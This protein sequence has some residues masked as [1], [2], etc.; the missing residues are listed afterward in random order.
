MKNYN[1]KR[2]DLEEEDQEE[3]ERNENDGLVRR[4]GFHFFIVWSM[5]FFVT[6]LTA[7]LVS[8]AISKPSMRFLTVQPIRI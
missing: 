4:A 3:D 7:N 1:S 5:V 6:R 2:E 8:G